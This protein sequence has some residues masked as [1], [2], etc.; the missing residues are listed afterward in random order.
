MKFYS[1]LFI[2]FLIAFQVNKPW[3]E[4]ISVD[5]KFRVMMPGEMVEKINEIETDIGTLFYYTYLYQSA[6]ED[7]ENLVYKISYVDYP[8]HT[9]HS[10]STDFVEDFFHST[11]E[12]SIQSVRGNLRYAD[13]IEMDNYPGRL[14]RVDYNKGAATIKT[15]AFMV[16]RRYYQIQ[17]IGRR[18]KSLNLVQDKFFESFY[19]IE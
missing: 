4:F 16:G 7:A 3:K 1:I 14:W 11:I 5:G 8:E 9:I 19:L 15:K 13:D 17:V 2:S 10:D 18:E 6:K 12:T